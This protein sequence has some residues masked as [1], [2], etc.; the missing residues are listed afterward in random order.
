MKRSTV[1]RQRTGRYNSHTHAHIY[2]RIYTRTH[3]HT[4][5]YTH[6]HTHTH[7]HIHTHICAVQNVPDHSSIFGVYRKLSS[8]QTHITHTHTH[9]HA[10]WH[11]YTRTHTHDAHA[12][13]R[14]CTRQNLYT[15][16]PVANGFLRKSI[17]I[18]PFSNEYKFSKVSSPLN[19][20]YEI[21]TQRTFENI[22]Q[23]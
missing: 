20:L 4:H 14:I 12:H 13:I 16:N 2:T 5:T 21:I 9:T 18:L 17:S 8:E 6:T 23:L 22:N 1:I 10:R 19:S 11:A 15:V 7:T 3:T